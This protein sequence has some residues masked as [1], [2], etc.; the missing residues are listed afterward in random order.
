MRRTHGAGFIL[1]AFLVPLLAG[2]ATKG[3]VNTRIDQLNKST[4]ARMD[5]I[6]NSTAEALARAESAGGSATEARD[7]AVGRAGLEEVSAHTVL[8]AFDSDELS[9]EAQAQLEQVA[10]GVQDDPEAIID[11][12]GSA[13][14][15]GSGRYNLELA[16][17]RA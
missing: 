6:G 3:Y 12:Y 9:G 16:Q 17:R 4:S 11:V 5:T 2:C 14:P 10:W 13:E 8:F 15:T 7:M 1:I